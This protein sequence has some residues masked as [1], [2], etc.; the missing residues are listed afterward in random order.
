[1]TDAKFYSAFYNKFHTQKEL[2][3]EWKN[4]KMNVSHWQ[5]GKLNQLKLSNKKILSI[6]ARAGIV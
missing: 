2:S 4:R 3:S 1:L 6:G 5:L